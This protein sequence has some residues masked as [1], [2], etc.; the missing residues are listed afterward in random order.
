MAL[1]MVQ[2]SYTADSW[3]AMVKN[4]QDRGEIVGRV[5]E[6][7]GGKMIG[8]WLTFGDYDLVSIAE[9][10]DDVTMAA[11]AIAVAAG[12][13]CSSFKTTALLSGSDGMRAMKKAGKTAYKPAQKK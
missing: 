1:Y 12:G 5:I 13:A 11:F 3:S 7:M 6:K 10:P 9:M 8:F 4:P 2:A